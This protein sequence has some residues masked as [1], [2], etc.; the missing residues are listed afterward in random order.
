MANPGGLVQNYEYDTRPFAGSICS[1]DSRNRRIFES[2]TFEILLN[3]SSL[4]ASAIKQL[5]LHGTFYCEVFLLYGMTRWDGRMSRASVSHFGRSVDSDLT[6]SN[7][8]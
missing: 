3:K 6:G 8:G 1:Q 4:D 2:E 7:L 5:L